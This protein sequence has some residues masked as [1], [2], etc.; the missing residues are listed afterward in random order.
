MVSRRLAIWDVEVHG[1]VTWT[2]VQSTPGARNHISS[3]ALV[4][5]V[6][7]L[8]Y[9]SSDRGVMAEGPSKVLYPSDALVPFVRFVTEHVLGV[10]LDVHAWFV[11][12]GEY[13]CVLG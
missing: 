4:E 7:P 1:H 5:W 10:E 9:D 11:I 8:H 2:V 3:H 12:D 6:S 13:M